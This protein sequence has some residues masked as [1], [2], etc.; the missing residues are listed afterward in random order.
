MSKIF[1]AVEIYTNT[2]VTNSTYGIVNGVFR[3]ITDR[4]GYDLSTVIPIY[5][6]DEIDK[7]GTLIGGQN[8]PYSFREGIFTK[9]A[10]TT[11]H[12]KSIDISSFGNY[13]TDSQFSFK[14]RNDQIFWAFC[15]NNGINL[16]NSTCIFWIVIDNVFYQRARGKVVNNPGSEVDY[17]FD[18]DDD[19][20]LI[21]KNIPP[22]LSVLPVTSATQAVVSPAITNG[23]PI[24][25][26]F[27]DVPYSK[28]LKNN[29]DNYVVPLNPPYMAAAALVGT[30]TGP[31]TKNIDGTYSIILLIGGS[32]D[33]SE[34]AK[35][36]GMY[37]SVIAG[38]FDS[39]SGQVAVPTDKIYKILSH[40]SPVSFSS[41]YEITITISDPLISS[42]SGSSQKI[43]DPSLFNNPSNG[44]GR[45]NTTLLGTSRTWWFE[46][47]NYSQEAY[48]SNNPVSV[49]NLYDYNSSSS[50]YGDTTSLLTLGEGNSS[51][52][53]LTANTATSDGKVS[54]FED[55]PVNL[56]GFGM[57][58]SEPQP[59]DPDYHNSST[60]LQ[61]VTDRDR[62]T[63]VTM[64]SVVPGSGSYWLAVDYKPTPT[65]PSYLNPFI[66]NSYD[67]IFLCIDFDFTMFLSSTSSHMIIGE[68]T[69][70]VTDL[71]G[72][73]Y[74][75]G[76]VGD[77][78]DYAN[79]ISCPNPYSNFVPNELQK[80]QNTYGDNF[81]YFCTPSQSGGLTY[82]YILKI[83]DL[84][85]SVFA[86]DQIS[87]VRIKILLYSQE[88]AIN[89][90]IKEIA[91]VG[92]RQID[93]I[94]ADVFARTTGE[95]T[96]ATTGP[97]VMVGGSPTYPDGNQ[98]TGDVYHAFMH[99]LE[100]YDNIPTKL[101]DYG[102]LKTD[103][104]ST[105]WA[106]SRTLTEQ[107]N[108]SEYLNELCAQ[109]FVGMFSGRTGKRVLRVLQGFSGTLTPT[110]GNG[111]TT[112]HDKTLIVRN[113]LSGFTKTDLNN[114]YNSFL[115]QYAFNPGSNNMLRSFNVSNVDQSSFPSASTPDPRDST[116]PKWWSYFSG[117]PVSLTDP[118]NTLSDSTATAFYNT[119]A[120]IWAACHAAYL[121][122]GVVRISQG[123][124]SSLAWFGDSQIWSTSDTTCTGVTSSAYLLLQLLV[125]WCTIQKDLIS[126]SIPIT[127]NT[128]GTE[129]LDIVNFND[130]IYTQGSNRKGW[131]VGIETDTSK[132]QFNLNLILQPQ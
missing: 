51:S 101:I 20:T 52:I 3:F 16:S 41:Y 77:N 80:N 105:L 7:T 131:I 124:V 58:H 93:T 100:D 111:K 86:Q 87:N 55:I 119:A 69:L 84:S 42:G 89:V 30:G 91:I 25:V 23:E 123:D 92:E 98:S 53:E 5:G 49:L 81:C 12:S 46:I 117:F 28:I 127:V 1:Y 56:I 104:F 126:Y 68:L 78:P 11:N 17:E 116:K 59:T 97:V 19:A 40:T 54:K 106:V 112:T 71:S 26:V 118:F 79:S 120:S 22:N 2:T 64:S 76:S 130:T 114:V 8:V 109:S 35:I 36:D 9:E 6:P 67:S 24:P 4:P 102:T 70:E 61:K 45:I 27:G 90:A 132:D 38:T 115:M 83:P 15:N 125:S 129:L 122:N 128:Y 73:V 75:I 31:Y 60:D 95:L 113:S 13:S 37:L 48:V 39:G 18:I 96:G 66:N 65:R 33:L 47:S 10:I 29:A 121:K 50:A 103:R 74:T 99:I 85:P 32:V 94:T 110:T 107:K 82:K 72:Y 43:L 14:V 34:I 21:H 63:S 62:L 88:E 57:S 44:Y 108:S